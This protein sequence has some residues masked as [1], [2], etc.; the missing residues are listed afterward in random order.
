MGRRRRPSGSCKVSRTRVTQ[1][2][3]FRRQSSVAIDALK[4]MSAEAKIRILDGA[5]SSFSLLSKSRNELSGFSG[6]TGV[7]GTL[8]WSGMTRPSEFELGFPTI[9]DCFRIMNTRNAYFSSS[10]IG[11]SSWTWT[12]SMILCGGSVT[13]LSS[14]LK[15]T[16][17]LFRDRNSRWWSNTQLE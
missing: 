6:D 5:F 3:M 10:D 17:S 2:D 7:A 8:K 12:I 13:F 9:S 16:S 1:H 15:A 4:R 11:S 14:R